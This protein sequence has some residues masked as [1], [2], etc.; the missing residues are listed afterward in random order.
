M[1]FR[2]HYSFKEPKLASHELGFNI[3]YGFLGSIDGGGHTI[4]GLK[5]EHPKLKNLGIFGSCGPNSY[6]HDIIIEEC[7]FSGN[8]ALNIG[9]ITGYAYGTKIEHCIVRNG[10]ITAPLIGGGIVGECSGDSKIRY[11]QFTG[12]ITGE[13]TEGVNSRLGGMIG[14]AH[15][16]KTDL[17]YIDNCCV[18]ASIT[19]CAYGGG[20]LSG[21]GAILSKCFFCGTIRAKRYAAGIVASGNLC[22]V[23]KCICGPSEIY[24]ES[25]DPLSYTDSA[26]V[27]LC[28]ESGHETTTEFLE[29]IWL[30]HAGRIVCNDYKLLPQAKYRNY[31]A[32]DCRLASLEKNYTPIEAS[33]RDGFTILTQA[34]CSASFYEEINWEFISPWEIGEDH[35]PQIS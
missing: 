13:G 14:I 26:W 19:N 32:Q 23:E 7:S 15:T 4:S 12:T 25:N 10:C 30:N 1:L 6:I 34:L 3:N 28:D 18:K 16:F 21:S 31:A 17:S 33:L 24:Y 27:T 20:I 22:V 2:S 5:C 11:C 35:F 8:Q 29:N 9:S